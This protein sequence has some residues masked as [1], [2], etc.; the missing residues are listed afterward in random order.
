MQQRFGNVVSFHC[1]SLHS[2]TLSVDIDITQQ[3]DN[4]HIGWGSACPT[5]TPL[6]SNFSFGNPPSIPALRTL[7]P[8][9]LVHDHL[10]AM[11]PCLHPTHSHLMGQLTNYGKGPGPRQRLH[12]SFSMSSTRIHSDILTVAPEMWTEDI[13][14]DPAWED[15]KYETLLWRGTTT[16]TRME[17]KMPYWRLSQ[18]MRMV[19]MTNERTGTYDVLM[20]T[21]HNRPVGEPLTLEMASLNEKLMDIGFSGKPGQCSPGVC[22]VIAKEYKFREKQ[23]WGEANDHKYILDASTY[24]LN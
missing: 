4:Q 1:H 5:N 10:A 17:E 24:P 9:T 7:R 12:P 3:W 22:A 16:G 13:G 19:N 20:S 15:K 18:R 11:D 21:N 8:K 23:S 6:R 2:F 14:N